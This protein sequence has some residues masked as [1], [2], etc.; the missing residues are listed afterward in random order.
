MFRKSALS[1]AVLAFTLNLAACGGNDDTPPVVVPVPVGDTIALTV[2]GRLISFNRTTPAT[3]VGGIAVTGLASG[4][5]LLGI[6]VRPA[7]NTLYGLG[8][9]G[10]IY[11]IVPSTGVATRVTGLVNAA[12][13]AVAF[14]ALSGTNF[15]LDFNPAADRLRVI[16]NTG[17]NLRINVAT[18]ETF[19]DLPISPATSTVTAS[20]YTNAFPGAASTRLFNLNLTSNTLDLQDPP[21]NGTQVTGP[22]LGVSA[23]VV[24]GFD[25]D[26]RD[27]TGYAALT[28]GSTTSLYRINLSATANAATLVA[29][30]AGG[31]QI[32]GLALL[33]PLTVAG[34]TNDNRI[35]SFDPR[36]PNT[37]ISNVAITGL[38]AGENILGMDV[39]PADGL[40][41]ALSSAGR[42]FTLNV[43]TGAATFVVALSADPADVTLPLFTALDGSA[44]LS[45]D[46]NPVPDRMRVI[47]PAGQNLRINVTTGATSAD[48]P[49]NR[50]SAAPTVLAAAYSNSFPGVTTTTLYNLEGNTDILTIQ[51]PPND[52]TL[53]NVGTGLVT[54]LDF[55]SF[56]GLDIAGG[57]NGLVLAAL[58]SGTSGP[59]SL[60]SVNLTTGAATLYFNTSGNSALSQIGGASGPVLRDIAIL[61][62]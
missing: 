10:G 33:Q 41:W 30:I 32:R 44:T 61:R 18:G 16:S 5:T 34:L 28:V 4:E 26:A 48:L 52:G 19:N 57:D 36:T 21:N 31:E 23:A 7:N 60:Y 38:N 49:I 55:S 20:A 39:R 29:A 27:N 58:R 1:S 43:S 35:V 2:T 22:T 17:Q 54:G 14:T 24:N 3:L 53:T 11:T 59:L 40:L 50:A 56:A 42:L 46:F 51:N 47:T 9:A 12:A 15:G 13:N 45:V 62:N 8:S 37:L 6:D 25:I